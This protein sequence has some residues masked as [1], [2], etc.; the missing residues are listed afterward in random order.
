MALWDAKKRKLLIAVDPFATRPVYYS[1][2]DGVL[3][4]A[5]R[6]SCIAGLPGIS[7]EIDLNVVYFYLNHS[8]VPAPFTIYRD[9]RRLEPGQY[10]C[11][12]DGRST[13][14]Q[15]W[16]LQYDEDPSLSVETAADLIRSTVEQSVRSYIGAAGLRHARGG[17]FL[18]RRNGQQ[19]PGWSD[20]QSDKRTDQDL[21]C[22][23]R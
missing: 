2:V 17:R 14:R 7:R 19:H 15:Y 5:P 11:W 1:C 8:F 21:L 12:Q 20:D 6:V 4:F 23:V 3:V 9:I 16:D 18:K 13:V 22:G 10:L